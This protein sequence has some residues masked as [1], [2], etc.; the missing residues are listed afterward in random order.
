MTES[1]ELAS[2]EPTSKRTR[3]LLAGVR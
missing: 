1:V 2:N 3:L